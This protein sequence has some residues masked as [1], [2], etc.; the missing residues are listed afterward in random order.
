MKCFRAGARRTTKN[1]KRKSWRNFVSS[2][3]YKTQSKRIWNMIRAINGKRSNNPVFHLKKKDGENAETEEEIVNTLAENYEQQSSSQKHSDNFQ[4]TK[5]QA[6]KTNLNF[7]SENKENYN[8]IFSMKDLKKA[9]KKAKNSSEGGDKI[10][11]EIIKHLPHSSLEILLEII[12]KIW[13]DGSFPQ[14]WRHAIIIPIPKPNKDYTMPSSYRPI[15][16]TSCLC[17]TMERMVNIRL[18]WY[19][20]KGGFFSKFQCGFRKERNTIDHLVRLETYIRRA[21]KAGEQCVA[22]F[23]DLEKAYD[24]TWKYGIMRDLH[25]AGLRGRM[26]TFIG[27]FLKDRIFQVKLNGT[28]SPVHDQEMGVPQG[29]ILSVTLFVLKINNLAELIDHDVLRSLFVDDFK[30]CYRGKTMNSIERKLQTNLNKIGEWATDN[31]FI[32]SYDKTESV[33]FWKFKG[34]RKPELT[35]NNKPIKVSAKAKFLGLIWDRGLTFKDHIQYLRGKCLKALGM[36]RVL[37]HTDWGADTYTLLNLYKSFIRPKMDYGCIV[38]SS[39]S[40][41]VLKRLYSVNNEALRI[42]TGAFKTSP[43]SSLYAECHEMPPQYR[44]C[45]LALQYAIK[46][47]SNR[48]NPAY[49]D[50]FHGDDPL[51]DYISDDALSS[52]EEEPELLKKNK[53]RE[54][55]PNEKERRREKRKSLPPTFCERLQVEAAQCDIPFDYIAQQEIPEVEPWLIQGPKID[56]TLAYLPKADTNPHQYEALFNEVVDN[57]SSHTHIYTDG[58]KMDEK[59]GSAATWEFGTLKTRLPNGS[60]IFSAEAVA[61]IDA[62]KIIKDSER[63]KFIIFADSLSCI[64]DIENE[65]LANTLIQKFITDHEALLKES[66]EVVLCW[67]PSHTGIPGNEQADQEAKSSLARD[68][69]PLNIPFTDFL[70][71][72]KQYYHDLWQNAWES[73]TD[74]LAMIHPELKKKVYDPSLTRREQRA[75]C[76]I[77]I[78]HSRLTHAY[79]MDKHVQQPRCDECNCNLSIKHIMVDC[80]KFQEERENFLVGCTTEEI[81]NNCDRAIINFARERMDS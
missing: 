27:N 44:H 11:Y 32:F 40:H 33:H 46:L 65:D 52:D 23:F 78:G 39:A 4:S 12:N 36:L 6:E 14:I 61:L 1:S 20:E 60:S 43:T 66:K 74:F 31:G 15:S 38:Y 62:L 56:Y 13:L 41:S 54:D 28:L 69:R 26:T 50:I 76:R 68:I 55:S 48:Q 8:R 51:F 63:K 3:N 70:P 16:L 81:L 24:T 75:L 17:K 29:S 58:S 57:H 53:E 34:S 2:I 7:K 71:K 37:S 25:N 9:I 67:I 49:D 73:S 72:A 18:V 64:Q 10:H 19:L 22:V 45:Q 35:L 47:K 79:K 21:F 42:C 30:I 59:V 77:R 5:K 80:P